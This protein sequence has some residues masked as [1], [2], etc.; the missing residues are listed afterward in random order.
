[1]RNGRVFVPHGDDRLEKGDLVILFVHQDELD[2]VHLF[3]PGRE[4]R[5]RAL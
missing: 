5:A 2:T 3:F 1:M 4:D